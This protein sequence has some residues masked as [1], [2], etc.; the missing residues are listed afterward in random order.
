MKV[1]GIFLGLLLLVACWCPALA[2]EAQE[3]AQ[4]LSR[5]SSGPGKGILLALAYMAMW[6]GLGAF[7]F[8][9]HMQINKTKD[10]VT[11]LGQQLRDEQR[12][13]TDT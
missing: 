10:E 9:I 7:L 12:N 3:A 8:Y 6:L 5:P 2:A 11:W 1:T 4:E 13:D